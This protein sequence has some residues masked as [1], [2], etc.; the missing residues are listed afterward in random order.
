MI[1]ADTCVCPS[2]EMDSLREKREGTWTGGEG[3]DNSGH[4]WCPSVEMD[5]LREEREWTWTGGR[6]GGGVGGGGVG[7]TTHSLSQCTPHPLCAPRAHCLAHHP[8]HLK[9]SSESISDAQAEGHQRGWVAVRYTT[10]TNS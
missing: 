5:S 3:G 6:G 8:P 10:H 9:P 2:V 7:H 4:V 1:I